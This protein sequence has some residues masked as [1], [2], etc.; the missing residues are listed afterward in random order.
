MGHLLYTLALGCR[1]MREE[2]PLR[3]SIILR[4]FT[5]YKIKTTSN[6]LAL[7]YPTPSVEDDN[8]EVEEVAKVTVDESG[9]LV[10]KASRPEM[11]TREL[12]EGARAN[13]NDFWR[14]K[15]E[16]SA[17]LQSLEDMMGEEMVR[18]VCGEDVA[19]GGAD[20]P[21]SLEAALK[22]VIA[23]HP[24][25]ER[26]CPTWKLAIRPTSLLPLEWLVIPPA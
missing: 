9:N 24:A 15:N 4:A 5:Q 3:M 16:C 25:W 23:G 2:E 18:R 1:K 26:S 10:E 13:I 14:S 12:L 8:S 7:L 11:S 17:I 21:V 6:T 20:H 19:P 22:E